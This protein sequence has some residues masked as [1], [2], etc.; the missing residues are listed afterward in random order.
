MRHNVYWDDEAGA[1]VLEIIGDV[2]RREAE[3]IISEIKRLYSG[4]SYR[5]IIVDLG[6]S[7]ASLPSDRNYKRWLKDQYYSIGFDGIAIV[8][9]PLGLRILARP[10][11][12]RHI[13]F[14]GSM[15]E[16]INWFA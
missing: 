16:A 2:S 11:I 14:F 15:R 9:A 4:E 7:A 8:N 12:G 6:R 1:V 5:Y 13:Q 10:F 3:E